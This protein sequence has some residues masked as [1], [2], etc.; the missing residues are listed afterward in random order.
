MTPA[1]LPDLIR[2]ADYGGNWRLFMDAVYA[3]FTHDFLIERTPFM[4]KPVNLKKHPIQNGYEATFWHFISA[5]EIEFQREP[6]LERCERIRWPKAMMDNWSNG[7]I[8]IWRER[9]NGE[10]RIH[11]FC[12]AAKYLVVIA[13]RGTYVLPWTAYPI[14]HENQVR[15]LI[16]RWREHGPIEQ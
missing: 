9:R 6:A 3:A 8:K 5:G 12:E 4:G 1:W 16:K 10:S 11:L 14:E 15:K 7:D 13:D 2:L